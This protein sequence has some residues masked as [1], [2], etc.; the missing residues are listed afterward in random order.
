MKYQ[1]VCLIILMTIMALG[2]I[3]ISLTGNWL[4]TYVIIQVIYIIIHTFEADIFGDESDGYWNFLG[5]CMSR[6]K[7]VK[8]VTLVY[9][10]GVLT[11][12]YLSLLLGDANYTVTQIFLVVFIYALVMLEIKYFWQATGSSY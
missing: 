10:G 11:T 8:R 7:R 4:L 12:Y 1:R 5:F 2:L 3:N 6:R 9:C